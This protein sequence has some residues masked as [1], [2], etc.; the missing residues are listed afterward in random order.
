VFSFSLLKNYYGTFLHT[1]YA[2]IC[3]ISRVITLAKVQKKPQE[4]K[5]NAVI[6]R[7]TFLRPSAK[8]G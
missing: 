6:C 3:N 7:K 2:W 8:L 4:R 5:R 1:L